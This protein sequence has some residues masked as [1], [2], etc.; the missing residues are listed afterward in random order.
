[1]TFSPIVPIKARY[2]G[3]CK[4]CGEPIYEGEVAYYDT[5]TR[6][7]YCPDCG[8]EVRENQEGE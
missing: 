7:V 6:K 3:V 4:E 1:M 2:D 5:A 8:K